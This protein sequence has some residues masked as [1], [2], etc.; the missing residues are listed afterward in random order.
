MSMRS[1][2]HNVKYQIKKLNDQKKKLTIV[3]QCRPENTHRECQ[4]SNRKQLLPKSPPFH[5]KVER[6]NRPHH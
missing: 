1:K 4:P 2:F 6:V 5:A 3:T